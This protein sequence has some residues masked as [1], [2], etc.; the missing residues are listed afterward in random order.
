MRAIGDLPCGELCL[1]FADACNKLVD[2]ASSV[3]GTEA[4][5]LGLL[6]R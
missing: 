3:V 5:E 4:E 1:L 2:S 6:W